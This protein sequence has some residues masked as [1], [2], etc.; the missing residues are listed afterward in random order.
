MREQSGGIMRA[1]KA[2]V[3]GF[4]C[5]VAALFIG[6]TD[7]GIQSALNPKSS[8]AAQIALLWWAMLSVFTVVLLAVMVLLA[9]AVVRRSKDKEPS[10]LSERQKRNM[11]LTGGVIIPIVV[12][13]IFIGYSVVVGRY[14][15]GV[16]HNVPVTIEIVGHQWWWDVRYRIEGRELDVRT[17]NEIRLPIGVPV[18]IVLESRDVIH[19]FWMPNF[20]GKTDLIPG[21]KNFTWVTAT[22]PGV[23]R[24]QCAEFCGLQHA[25]MAFIVISEPEEDFYA[26]LERETQPASVPTTP[27]QVRGRDIFQTASC[28]MCH[29]VRGTT[30]LAEVAPDLTHVGSRTTL[31]AGTL[32]NTRGHLAGWL[33]NPQSIK[34]GS[35]MPNLYL[36]N[37]EL[38]ALTAYLESLK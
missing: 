37:E 2:A 19:S 13:F 5:V 24:G 4:F 30:A 12:L 15:A 28:T 11:V 21:R 20:Q 34:P 36:S 14:T 32:P 16:P 10:E 1:K 18:K 38:E 6:C 33:A 23:Y 22:D 17:A 8:Q 35:R 25:K 26:W 31:A 27:E 7:T 3:A 9:A 29:T